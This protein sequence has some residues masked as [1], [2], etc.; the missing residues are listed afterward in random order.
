MSLFQTPILTQTFPKMTTT[1]TPD[2]LRACTE[3]AHLKELV[4]VLTAREATRR[5]ARLSSRLQAESLHDVSSSSSSSSSYLQAFLSPYTAHYAISASVHP[6]N[7]T[8]NRYADI[9]A[10]D[11]TR[12]VV[13]CH[14]SRYLNAS[15]VRERIGGKWWIASQAP[16]PASAH[17]FL[18]LVLSPI[19][20]PFDHRSH[21]H[22][23]HQHPHDSR[24][25]TVVQLTR[26]EEGGR[27]KADEYFPTVV[28]ESITL[29][30]D[31]L[32]PLTVKLESQKPVEEHHCV[33]STVSVQP[34]GGLKPHT[35]K[36]LFYYAWPDH[37]VADSVGLLDFARLVD[38]T[39]KEVPDDDSDPD[40]DP[41]IIV[42]CSAGI[43]RTG[44]FI[45][46]TSLLRGCH[47]LSPD[48]EGP[49]RQ[50]PTVADPLP[51]SSP[52][53]PLPDELKEDYVALEVDSLREQRPGMVERKEQILL[54]Y[55]T[56]VSAYERSQ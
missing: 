45:A 44:S 4:R 14:P 32:P 13:G 30:S 8:H 42:G 51:S 23:P 52:M 7:H 41:P 34:Q 26:N 29:H 54:V 16:L 36:H 21:H 10:Y 28:G 9:T 1:T 33:I 55:E 19:L 47:L 12:V 20:N 25:R 40:P 48:Q 50:T 46:V 35:F 37:G 18:S 38:Q 27:R 56:L 2:W 6:D 3:P 22:H 53:G 11:R 49:P 17:A 15:W 24:V 5:H 39:N 43:G 31:G